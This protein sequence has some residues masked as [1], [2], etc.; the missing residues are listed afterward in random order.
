MKTIV[1]T[2]Y[3]P[4]EMGIFKPDDPKIEFVKETI[5]RRIA[6]LLDGGL[7]WVLVSG[8]M[9]VE[10]WA[11]QVVLD[12]RENGYDI[13]LGVIPPFQDQEK[14]WPEDLQMMY[15][16]LTMTADF[17]KPVFNKEYEGPYQFKAKDQFLVEHSDGCLVLFDEET[18]GSPKFFLNKAKDQ[19]EKADYSILYITPMDLD[20]T[21]EEMRMSDPDY[22]SQ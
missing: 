10:M 6:G 13:K 2:G 1:I 14:R 11:A 4:I 7:E 19:K 12:L 22:W 15:E 9:G 20:E 21:V 3:K 17:F 8:Q 5:K 16:E 18:D